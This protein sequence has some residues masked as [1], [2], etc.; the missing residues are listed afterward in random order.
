MLEHTQP[1]SASCSLVWEHDAEGNYSEVAIRYVEHSQ[2]HYHSNQV[3]DA[4]VNE[5]TARAMVA[6][7]VSAFGPGVLPAA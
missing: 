7:L 4:E 5:P 3:T 6:L 1:I 2:D